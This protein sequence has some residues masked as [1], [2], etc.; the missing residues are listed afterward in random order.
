MADIEIK[1]SVAD[2][3]R[4]FGRAVVDETKV[5]AKK[6]GKQLVKSTVKR[7]LTAWQRFLRDFKFRKRRKNES[8]AAYL[9]ARSKAASRAWKKKNKGSTKKGMRRKTARRA[10]ER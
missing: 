1:G 4:L 7:A 10:Y 5:Q 6:A 2:I 8:S 3:A 9:S